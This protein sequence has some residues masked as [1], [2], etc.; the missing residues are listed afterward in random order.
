MRASNNHEARDQYATVSEFDNKRIKNGTCCVFWLITLSNTHT[1]NRC[2]QTYVFERTAYSM[3][4]T[5][6]KKEL[7]G[8]K[9]TLQPAHQPA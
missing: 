6:L 5:V 2:K 3:L 9:S 8:R 1:C 4:C 7:P